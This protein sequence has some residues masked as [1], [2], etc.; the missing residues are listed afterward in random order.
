MNLERDC[1]QLFTIGEQV[2]YNMS[3]CIDGTL[4]DIKQ[5]EAFCRQHM[6]DDD[7]NETNK[8][9]SIEHFLTQYPLVRDLLGPRRRHDIVIQHLSDDYF[10]HPKNQDINMSKYYQRQKSIPERRFIMNRYLCILCNERFSTAIQ[11]IEHEKSKHE[12]NVSQYDWGWNS[13][14]LI[15]SNPY[16]FVLELENELKQQQQ[17]TKNESTS[18]LM[19]NNSLRKKVKIFSDMPNSLLSH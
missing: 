2:A 6:D 13:I 5:N 12:K 17:R 16:G 14:G 19:S 11:L 18:F 7:D 1:Q 10:D 4:E 8:L 3:N 9:T 15:Q